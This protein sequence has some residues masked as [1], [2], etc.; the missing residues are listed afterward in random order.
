VPQLPKL[1]A[2]AIS[3]RLP[4]QNSTGRLWAIGSDGTVAVQVLG[5]SI[6][7]Y[8]RYVASYTPVLDDIV[9]M[10]WDTRGLVITGKLGSNTESPGDYG[11]PD[12]YFTPRVDMVP[13]FTGTWRD[14]LWSHVV[15]NECQ[16]GLLSGQQIM[17]CAYYGRVLQGTQLFSSDSYFLSVVRLP[18]PGLVPTKVT[19]G[20]L[21]G[22]APTD[23]GPTVLDTVTGLT[24]TGPGMGDKAESLSIQFQGW[25]DRFV[26]G[27]AGGLA[28]MHDATM[29][30]HLTRV[31]GAYGCSMN[32]TGYPA[33][34]L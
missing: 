21:A 25:E 13:V 6:L 24:L 8:V 30:D 1:I 12:L 29:G 15:D 14:G 7:N 16:F 34:V 20:L 17:G 19:V 18:S 5:G 31:A 9:V 26:S 22:Q 10:S 33:W 27:E 4:T 28:L 23:A 11:S 3:A 32:V 2:G